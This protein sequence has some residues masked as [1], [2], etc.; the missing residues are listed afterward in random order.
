MIKIVL[1]TNNSHKVG[2]FRAAFEQMGVEVELL[3]IKDTDFKGE[4]IEDA[5]TFDG[6]ALIKAKTL[7]ESTGLVAIADDSGLA[8]DAL[9]GEPGVYSA[10]YAGVGA[11]DEQN[12][13]KLLSLLRSM[14]DAS[15]DAKFVCSI[16]V[17]R[18]DGEILY[19][20]GESKGE[21]ID[22]YRGDGRFGYDPIFYYPPMKKTF[23]EMTKEEK[24]SISHRGRAIKELLKSKEFFIK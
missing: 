7:C 15:R 2:E 17:C 14:P 23:A 18:P 3:T 16:C 21:I 8:V 4:I 22:E 11:T 19:A 5:D 13:E 9:N 1:A 10:R 6:N 24:N 20:H 12:N